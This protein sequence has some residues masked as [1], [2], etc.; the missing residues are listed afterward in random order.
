M[1]RMSSPAAP[2][3]P[4]ASPGPWDLVSS[5]Y[6]EEIV[7]QFSPYA[8]D[9]LRLAGVAGGARVSLPS[10]GRTAPTGGSS[11]TANS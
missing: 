5:A 6:A 4:L 2:A 9:A 7:P 8:E 11:A 3:S 1:G 10:V